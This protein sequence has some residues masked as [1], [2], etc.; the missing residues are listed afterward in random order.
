MEAA[1]L[2]PRNLASCTSCSFPS[3]GAARIRFGS[4]S[5]LAPT[6]RSHLTAD[7]DCPLQTAIA[8]GDSHLAKVIRA[9]ARGA[10]LTVSC[11]HWLIRPPLLTLRQSGPAQLSGTATLRENAYVRT[12]LMTFAASPNEKLYWLCA[13]ACAASC[14]VRGAQISGASGFCRRLL[15]AYMLSA[16]CPFPSRL[17]EGA[18][19]S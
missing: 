9:R 3:P 1:T 12:V 8:N 2:T 11:S 6:F 15:T 14:C 7:W 4:L 10:D 5:R 17:T 13:A 16:A 19:C 18:S